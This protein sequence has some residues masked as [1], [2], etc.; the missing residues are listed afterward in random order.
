MGSLSRASM[1]KGVLIAV[2]ALAGVCFCQ[3][4]PLLS[5]YYESLC[6]YSRAFIREEVYPTYQIMSD[7]FDVEFIAYGNA[8]T[9]GVPGEEGFYIDC[10]HGDRECTGNIVQACTVNYNQDTFTQV[11]L[12]NCMSAASR[13]EEAGEACYMELG[14]DFADTKVCAEGPEGSYSTIKMVKFTTAWSQVH[15]EYHGLLGMEWEGMMSSMKWMPLDFM[16]T[17]VNTIPILYVE[18]KL[19]L[20]TKK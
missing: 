15:G 19:P 7:Y 14:L 16:D 18:N 3:E 17:F 8:R 2:F 1:M 20:I 10:Q 13:P 12:L 4:K 5:V 6:P 11:Y 9:Y